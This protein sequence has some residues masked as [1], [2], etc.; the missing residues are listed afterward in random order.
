MTQPLC[1]TC[2]NELG[3][4][5]WSR[6]GNKFCCS[7][8]RQ[9]YELSELVEALQD[10]VTRIERLGGIAEKQRRALN[11]VMVKGPTDNE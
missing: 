8:C 9:E 10:A 7:S 5:Y 3:I 6:D 11:L 2:E 4:T 1:M